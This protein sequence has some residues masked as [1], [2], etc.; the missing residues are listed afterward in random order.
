VT[1]NGHCI[2][3][4]RGQELFS[5]RFSFEQTQKVVDL[6][7]KYG[8]GLLMKYTDFSCLYS[9]PEEMFQVFNNIGLSRSAFRVC[10]DMDYHYREL[11]I[12]FTIRGAEGIKRELA[13]ISQDFR[14]ELFHDVTECDVFS[15]SLN[16]MTALRQLADMLCVDP[17]NCIAFGDSR[18]DIEM[19]RWAG[20]GVAMGNSCQD[21]KDVADTVCAS[22]WEDGIAQTVNTLLHSAA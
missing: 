15:P 4:A 2:Q 18:N 17:R 13:A 19:I 3:D 21:L 5:H 1:A 14:I 9:N 20:M 11:P 22:S 10:T 12:G 16:K 7:K 8:N 6:T